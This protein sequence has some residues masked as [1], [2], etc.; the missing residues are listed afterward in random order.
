MGKPAK[1][2]LSSGQGRNRTADTR[3]FSPLLYQLSYPSRN[4]FNLNLQ[5]THSTKKTQYQ[6]SLVE[7]LSSGSLQKPIPTSR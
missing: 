1:G 6:R 5:D 7:P 2:G 3:I 4:I